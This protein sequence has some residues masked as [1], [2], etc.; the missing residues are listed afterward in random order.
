MSNTMIRDLLR[1]EWDNI[2]PLIYEY[3]ITLI[4][5][6]IDKYEL[7]PSIYNPLIID[8]DF[9]LYIHN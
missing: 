4:N 2:K 7:L 3:I 8:G 6:K 5:P 9:L 1:T